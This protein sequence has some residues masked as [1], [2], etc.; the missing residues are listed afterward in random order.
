MFVD[1]L[2]GVAALAVALFHF[3]GQLSSPLALAFKSYGWLGV[4][5]FFVLSGF[6]I[7]LSLQ[8]KGYALK[9]FPAFLLR[10]LV[11]LEPPYLEGVLSTAKSFS[12]RVATTQIVRRCSPYAAL[13]G[14][15]AGAGV[16]SNA[17]V[18]PP[19]ARSSALYPGEQRQVTIQA[20]FAGIANVALAIMN[21]RMERCLA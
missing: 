3:S 1:A 11:R 5:V 16:R 14:G 6:V 15:T 13:D 12:Q 20:I 21:M 18:M 4:D 8:G 7:S 19:D 9:D 10:R 2:R 17:S